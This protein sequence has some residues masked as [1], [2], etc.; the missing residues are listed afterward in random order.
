MKKIIIQLNLV[1]H[2][3]AYCEIQIIYNPRIKF[4][5]EVKVINHEISLRL[6]DG[7]STKKLMISHNDLS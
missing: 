3:S 2:F 5:W 6:L 4:F 1:E 7:F